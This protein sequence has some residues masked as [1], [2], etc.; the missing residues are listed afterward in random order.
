MALRR[1][2]VL[3]GA[4]G[5]A[6]VSGVGLVGPASAAN[7]TPIKPLVPTT[8]QA[9]IKPPAAAPT[10]GRVPF[11][12]WSAK[13]IKDR[14]ASNARN[15]RSV[16]VKG[17]GVGQDETYKWD[18]VFTKTSGKLSLTSTRQGTL[19]LV[20]VGNRLFVAGDEKM[21][22][23]WGAK[24]D[25]AAVAAGKWVEILGNSANT[26][27]IRSFVTMGQ[28]TGL[29]SGFKPAKRVAGKKVGG[30]VTIGLYEPGVGGE[31]LYVN[32]TGRT[33]PVMAESNDKTAVVSYSEWN[34]S[35]R[36]AVPPVTTSVQG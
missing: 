20:R 3:I 9:S 4:F 2:R 33:F 23:T 22:T 8:T 29:L 15:A 12:G 19:D 21:W 17:S 5:L 10:T 34:R 11:R 30:Q 32:P 6:V 35:V 36:I 13:R 24:P 27:K 16:H 26:Q 18:G 25:V 14:A 31:V 28:W 7:I 1:A